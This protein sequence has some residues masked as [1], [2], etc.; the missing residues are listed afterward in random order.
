M[1]FMFFSLFILYM[2]GD[3]FFVKNVTYVKKKVVIVCDYL[4][5]YVKQVLL[6]FC[7]RSN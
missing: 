7:F 2:S 3:L 1:I 6:R 5:I 4:I